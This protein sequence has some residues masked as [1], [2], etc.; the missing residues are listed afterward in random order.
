VP[1]DGT[2]TEEELGADLRV[3]LVAGG[4]LGDLDLLRGELVEC[5]DGALAHGLA[6]G[7]ELA[8]GSLGECFHAHRAELSMRMMPRSGAGLGGGPA[9][10]SRYVCP[11]VAP[12]VG[13]RCG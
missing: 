11:T 2:W 5:V 6:G 4:A 8:A 12:R 13:R 1:F 10:T 9:P 7:H 3:G